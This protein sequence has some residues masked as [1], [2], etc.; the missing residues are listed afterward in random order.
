MIVVDVGDGGVVECADATRFSTDEHN[1]LLLW[2]GRDADRLTR[3]FA[4][5]V[6]CGVDV[7]D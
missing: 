7:E 5:G 6:W 3:V 2:T 4:Q 1:N